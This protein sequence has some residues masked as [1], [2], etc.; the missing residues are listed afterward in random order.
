VYI[1]LQRNDPRAPE[2]RQRLRIA[3]RGIDFR[4]IE[5]QQF[6]HDGRADAAIG[7]AHQYD[8]V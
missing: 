7:A 2:R 4:H 8:L 3:R 5:L 1:H 6:L